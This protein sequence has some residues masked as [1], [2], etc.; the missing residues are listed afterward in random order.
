ML[1]AAVVGLVLVGSA[2]QGCGGSSG[3]S[4]DLATACN[5]ACPTIVRCSGGIET[6]AKCLTDCN[7]QASCTNVSAI[8]SAGEKCEGMSDCTAVAQCS[9]SVPDCIKGGGTAGASGG[10]TAGASGGG[11]AGASGGGTAGTSGT[12]P[13]GT[14]CDTACAK[15]DACAAAVSALSHTDAGIGGSLKTECDAQSAADQ[16]STV[17]ACNMILSEAAMLGAVEP[18]ACK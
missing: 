15:A 3:G 4:G 6:M 1:G 16:L 7:A 17:A 9:Q 13:G 12:M 8:I 2:T 11:T 14:T 10:G 18:A 5:N